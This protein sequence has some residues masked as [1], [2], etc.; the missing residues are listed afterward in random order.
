KVVGTKLQGV[1]V[2]PNSISWL[3]L[4]VVSSQGPGIFDGTTYIQRINTVGGKAP[5]T[6]ANSSTV[7]QSVQVPYTAEYSFYKA[8]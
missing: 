1:T 3:L 6:G 7:G 4:S 2:D 8:E 5:A